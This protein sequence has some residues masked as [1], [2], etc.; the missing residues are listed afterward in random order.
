MKKFAILLALAACGDNATHPAIDEVAEAA[1]DRLQECFPSSYRKFQG[2]DACIDHM[3]ELAH[4]ADP[5]AAEICTEEIYLDIS[6]AC[7][8]DPSPSTACE[9]VFAP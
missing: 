6:R 8:W 4:D 5:A 2:R 3:L 7:G 1:C 9:G